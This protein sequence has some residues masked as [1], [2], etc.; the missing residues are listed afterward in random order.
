MNWTI[1]AVKKL[2]ISSRNV[3]KFLK[4]KVKLVRTTVERLVECL[5]FDGGRS[6]LARDIIR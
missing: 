2:E 5:G 6:H 3:H 4:Y 1:P